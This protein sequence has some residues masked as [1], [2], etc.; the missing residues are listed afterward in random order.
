MCFQDNMRIYF[1]TCTPAVLKLNGLYAGGTDMFERHIEIDL[2]DNVLAEIVPGDNLQPVNFF[3]NEKLLREPP[4]FMDVYLADGDALIYVRRFESRDSRINIIFQ[5][6]FEGNLVTVFSQGEVYLSVEGKN[7]SLT[8]LG[9]RFKE[10]RTE[11]KRLAGYPVLALYGGDALVVISHTGAVIF[12]SEVLSVQFGETFKTTVR[13]ETCTA[14]QAN[15]EYSYNGEKLTLTFSRTEETEP[16]DEKILHFAFFESIL[17]FGDCEKYLSLELKPKAADLREY[18]GAFTGVT[19]PTEKFYAM[20]P[21]ERAAGLVY[22]KKANLHEIKY[23]SVQ[24]KDG[25][26]DNVYPVEQ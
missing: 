23:F 21:D 22:P 7:Y 13:F 25:K 5:T 2:S 17:T 20:H 3:I 11:E 18:L 1:L 8:A 12:S 14:A 6:R 9:S 16:P 24:L 15:C 10:V 26:V 4:D 19:V